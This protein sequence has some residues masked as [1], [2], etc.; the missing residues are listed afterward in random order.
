MAA[1]TEHPEPL[2]IAPSM[3]FGDRIGVSTIGHIRALREAGLAGKV[4]PVF[5]QQS[6]RENA[7]T[8]RTFPRVM[9]DAQQ[10]V[11][12]AGWDLPW[13]ADGDHLKTAADLADAARAGF[14]FF[15]IDPSDYVN[16]AAASLPAEQLD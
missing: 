6:V 3:G 2:S 13:G 14:A 5:A 1:I 16:D 12:A 9:A 7:R 4:A 8:G 11:R 10:A 15:T